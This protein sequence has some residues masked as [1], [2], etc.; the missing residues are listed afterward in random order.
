MERLSTLDGK[1]Y[2][3]KTCFCQSGADANIFKKESQPTVRLAI[4]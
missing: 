4:L 2:N 3:I 1:Y